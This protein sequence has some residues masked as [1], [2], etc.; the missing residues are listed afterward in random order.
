MIKFITIN[1]DGLEVTR[2]FKTIKELAQ[3]YYSDNCDL[4][5]NDDKIVYAEYDGC[6]LYYPKIFEELIDELNINIREN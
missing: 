6:R 5:A 3:E 2:E 4:P 1:V